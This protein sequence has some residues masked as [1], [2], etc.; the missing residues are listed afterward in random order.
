MEMNDESRL[1]TPADIDELVRLAAIGRDLIRDARGGAM[2]LARHA[3][4]EPLDETFGAAIADDAATIQVGC[5][6]D[7]PLGF[8]LARI[9]DAEPR[10][11]VV[12]ELFV[13]PEARGVAL[14]EHMMNAVVDW[15]A[16]AGCVGVDGYA[17]PG[18]RATKNFFETFGLVARGIVV[19]RAIEQ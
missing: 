14:G 3:P 1:A 10:I 11:A 18:D 16:A 9:D 17:L 5:I 6:D 2:W 13:L 4:P 7:V 8:I 19:H 15:A 12:E